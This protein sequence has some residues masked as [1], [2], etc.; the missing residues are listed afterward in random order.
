MTALQVTYLH[1]VYSFEACGI[2]LPFTVISCSELG[3]M[4]RCGGQG[5]VL[6]G[7]A[8]LFYFW[9]TQAEGK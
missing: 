9:A 6:S 3:S 4:R 5:D 2:L 7:I 1:V 8:A